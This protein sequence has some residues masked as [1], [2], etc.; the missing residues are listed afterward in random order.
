MIALGRKRVKKHFCSGTRNHFLE[1]ELEQKC[2]STFFI[3]LVTD[4]L[5]CSILPCCRQI[6]ADGSLPQVSEEDF[7][8][9]VGVPH[10]WLPGV[11]GVACSHDGWITRLTDALIGCGAVTDP[12]LR[13]MGPVCAVKVS[14]VLP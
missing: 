12:V 4:L 9:K 8:A 13:L 1:P 5:M 7:L 10:L 14:R 6:C 11:G 2:F 3:G